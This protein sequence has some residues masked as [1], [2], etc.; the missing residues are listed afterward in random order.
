MRVK[1]VSKLGTSRQMDLL[2]RL[3]K[4]KDVTH[5]TDDVLSLQVHS[6]MMPTASL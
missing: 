3:K 4:L 5:G 6:I 2:D 1:P